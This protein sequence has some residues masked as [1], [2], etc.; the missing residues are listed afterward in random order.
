MTSKEAYHITRNFKHNGT[1]KRPKLLEKWFFYFFNLK[2]EL[3]LSSHEYGMNFYF[4]NKKFD[5]LF[6]DIPLEEPIEVEEGNYYNNVIGRY[7]MTSLG[8][9]KEEDFLLAEDILENT[10]KIKK[11]YLIIGNKYKSIIDKEYIYL[12]RIEY[13]LF[14]VPFLTSD[15]LVYDIK[16]KK[17]VNLSSIHL[18]EEIGNNDIF[19]IIIFS[20]NIPTNIGYSVTTKIKN[21]NFM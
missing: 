18:T 8:L 2:D 19:D 21:I 5:K 9:V 4:T 11:R 7:A 10:P 6:K 1:Y 3:N 17:R 14:N 20:E 16:R 15:Y 13:A 12:G